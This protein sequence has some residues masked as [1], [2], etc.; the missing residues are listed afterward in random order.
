M[1][2]MDDWQ[3][4]RDYA[5]RNSEEAFRGLVDRYAGLVYHAAL[6]QSGNPQTAQDVAQAVFIALAR[7]ADRLPRGTV[8]S[9]WLFRATRFAFANLAREES[10]RQRREQEAVMMQDPLQPDETESVWKQITPLLDDAL[11]RLSAKDR[12]AILI[13]FFQ[14]K[15]HRETA[16][17][18]GVSEDAAKVR[19]SRAVEKLRLIFAARGVAAP[20]AVLL[21]AFAAHGAPAAPIGLTAAIASAAA[22][23]GTVGTT[24][25]LII[26]KGVLKIMAWTKAKTAIAVGAAII[27]ATGT[28]VVVVKETAAPT[29]SAAERAPVVMQT[30]WQIGKKYLM[31]LE[32]LQT[33]E[34]KNPGQTK[35][36]KQV[37]K[38]SQDFYYFPVRKLENGGW[39]LQL[40]FESLTLEVTNGNRKVF[41]ANSTQKPVQDPSNPVGARMRKMIGARLEYFTDA[42]GKAEQMNGYPELVTRVAGNN[43]Q[44]QAAFKDMF[45]EIGLEKLGSIL[46]DTVPRRV[47]KLGDRWTMSLKAPSNAGNLQVD[48]KCVFKNWEQRA[49]YKCMHITFTGTISAGAGSDASALQAKI[50]KGTVTGNIWFDPELGM[51]VESANDVNAQLKINQNGQ[52]Q[53]VPLN[54]KS[55]GTLLAVEDM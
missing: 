6:R 52:I 10:R 40:E 35:A 17:L 2:P 43:Q 24:S 28:T 12:E 21:A 9:G 18:L 5:Q 47:V 11:D 30:Q 41:A 51:A 22:A 7:K 37:R 1:N 26:A 4:L 48:L 55:R 19:V 39:Q 8:L 3:L 54:E 23:K 31:H 14:D 49:N 45:S 53:T 46:E 50:E 27:L 42:N 44:E 36:V 33:T 34:T 16:R 32:D 20:S 25:T 29:G 13:R 15:S 38:L